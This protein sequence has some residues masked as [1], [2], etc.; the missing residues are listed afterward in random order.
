MHVL[1]IEDDPRISE[2]VQRGLGARGFTVTVAA[3]GP[4]GIDLARRLDVD[5]VLLDLLLP[6]C[7][8]LEAIGYIRDSK[9]RLPVIALT[10]MDDTDARVKGLDAGADDY[11]TKP[12]AVEEVAARIR[13]RLRWRDDG[14]ALTAGGLTVDPVTHRAV[15]DGQPIELSARELA[16]LAAFLRHP[17]Q[18]LSRSQLLDLVWG[19]T[20]DSGSNLVDVYVAALRRK[21]GAEWIDTVR[22]LGYRLTV[23]VTAK[24]RL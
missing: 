10:A 9:P 22:G 12:F 13:A 3:D 16:V 4:S 15:L 8:G 7:P 2:I 20:F 17:S 1:L 19:V 11:I 21:L 24:D 5:V 18:V 14:A 6:G 23:P